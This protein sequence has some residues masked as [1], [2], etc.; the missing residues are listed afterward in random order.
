[1]GRLLDRAWSPASLFRPRGPEDAAFLLSVLAVFTG[2]ANFV[3]VGYFKDIS[4]DRATG[5]RTFP[6]VFGWRA[7]AVYGDITATLAAGL[8]VGALAL[9]RANALSLVVLAAAV[10]LYLHAQVSVHRTRDERATGTPI[11][12]GVRALVL[13]CLAVVTANEPRWAPWLAPFY[14]LFELTLWLRPER[15]QI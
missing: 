3:V 12:N 1:M 7:A 6:V 4:A 11:A 2:Y 8:A 13:L 9:L 5:Y 10:A 15:G 14:M